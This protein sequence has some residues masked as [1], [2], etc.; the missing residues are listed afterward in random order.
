MKRK[1]YFSLL[2]A[3]VTDGLC[4]H[5]RATLELSG[6]FLVRFF[7]DNVQLLTPVDPLRRR[8]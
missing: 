6:E 8:R 1:R 2:V 7:V 5:V 4:I 3:S